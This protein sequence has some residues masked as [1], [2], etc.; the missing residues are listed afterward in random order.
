MYDIASEY[1]MCLKACNKTW[2]VRVRSKIYIALR[3][4]HQTDR[5][6]SLV[7][8][9]P[10]SLCIYFYLS[11]IACSTCLLNI[12]CFNFKCIYFTWSVFVINSCNGRSGRG[13]V[14]QPG[15]KNSDLN[16]YF[17]TYCTVPYLTNN[18]RC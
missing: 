6:L 18:P 5:F 8:S 16:H 4:S 15:A 3:L 9:F 13:F 14:A 11:A 7:W 2:H 17:D 1:T 12:S 10:S